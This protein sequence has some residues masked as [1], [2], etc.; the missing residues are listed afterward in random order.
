MK[1]VVVSDTHGYNGNL[2]KVIEKE[3]PFDLLVHCGDLSMDIEELMGFVDCPVYA[4]AGNNDFFYNLKQEEMFQIYDKTVLLVHGHRQGVY[5]GVTNLL[6]KAIEKNAEIV[7]FGH[8]H[9]PFIDKIDGVTFINPGSLTYP[10]QERRIETY[11]ILE[12]SPDGNMTT[13][14]KFLY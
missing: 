11:A 7:M 13:E 1:V 4:C 12:L 5:N 3:K 2:I 10:R 8:T 9:E 14:L 6:Y